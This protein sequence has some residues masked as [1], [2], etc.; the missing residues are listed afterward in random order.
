MRKPMVMDWEQTSY[1]HHQ[2]KQVVADRQL[3]DM[4][5]ATNWQL[6]GH[7]SLSGL[8]QFSSW[9]EP[10]GTMIFT[11]RDGKP[12]LRMHSSTT[13]QKPN[14]DKGRG[15]G[16]TTC[17]R[18]FDHQDWREYNRISFDVYPD[19]PGFRIVSLCMI[20]YND[21]EMKLPN[22]EV[23]EGLHFVI[24]KNHQWNHV[25]WEFP[26]LGRENVVGFA[27]QYRLQGNEPGASNQISFDFT[28]LRLQRVDCDHARGWVPHHKEITFSHTG[29]SLKSNKTA[30]ASGLDGDS[31]Q[32][33]RLTDGETVFENTIQTCKTHTGRYQVLDFSSFDKPGRYF[34]QANDTIT[35]PFEIGQD[36]WNKTIEKVANFF[37][38]ERCGYPVPGVHDVCHADFM[39]RYKDQIKV[40]NGGWH[41]A[42]DLSQNAA[43]TAD[44]AVG[45]M[46]LAMVLKIK[47]PRLA[48]ILLD[49]ARWGMDYVLK[50]RFTDGA[51]MG[52]VALDFWSDGVIGNIDDIINDAKIDAEFNYVGAWSQAIAAKAYQHSDPAF[53]Y[54]CLNAAIEDF[55]WAEKQSVSYASKR[56][57][58]ISLFGIA[59]QAALE[60]YEV[61][62]DE[63]YLDVAIK[64]A[65]SILLSQ[66]TDIPDWDIP[67]RGFF[68]TNPSKNTIFHFPHLSQDQR[69]ICALNQLYAVASDHPNSSK[70]LQAIE[71]YAEYIHAISKFSQP[72][73]MIPAGIYSASPDEIMRYKEDP[74]V[75]CKLEE[76]QEQIKNGIRLSDTYYLRHFPV[77]HTLRGNSGIM[78]S[79]ARAILE[80]AKTL[81][82]QELL[83]I[84]RRQVEWH[85]G[86][87]PHNQSLI[88]G[89]GYNCSPQYSAMSGD[90]V[91]SLPVGVQT[92]GNEDIPY[93]PHS[94]CYNYKEVWVQPAGRW[95][96]LMEILTEFD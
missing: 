86:R 70:W 61:T 80:S 75:G 88:W 96:W 82:D 2:Q 67:I 47:N 34:I 42:G 94:N 83:E 6:M 33:I 74:T 54:R 60:L 11:Q 8:K 45:M 78:L 10:N 65:D 73:G 55:E 53:Y 49:E 81:N 46:K 31:F 59:V 91:G 32:L 1:W 17:Y 43:N 20:L 39:G 26:E 51:R 28:D 56:T 64:H 27:L 9:E 89:E 68:Y 36:I 41:D 48:E 50:T 84:G 23:R 63:K 85:V 52:F 44:A 72:Y 92:Q 12:V 15:W 14:P 90:I 4:S 77:W 21:G 3:D 29:Y 24:L 66:Q 30:I 93:Y 37:F 76:A 57:P 87:N 7:V 79:T 19:F 62:K 40:I 18:H 38:V 35:Q 22:D 71:L 13:T 95:L 58:L 69:P 25:T 5:H 16:V